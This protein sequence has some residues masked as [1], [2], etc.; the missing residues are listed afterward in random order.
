MAVA[1]VGNV[2]SSNLSSCHIERLLRYSDKSI[3]TIGNYLGFSSHA[4]FVR[5]FK[6]YA[7]TTPSE[8]RDGIKS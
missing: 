7:K 3:A 6:K 1:N 2:G 4:H 8:Y 5:V